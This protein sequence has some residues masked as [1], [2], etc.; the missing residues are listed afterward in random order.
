MK[1]PETMDRRMFLQTCA[2]AGAVLGPA[3]KAGARAGLQAGYDAKGLQTRVL[4]KTG[5]RIPIIVFG[6]ST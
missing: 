2:A 1:D 4:G 3:L 6:V 5:V